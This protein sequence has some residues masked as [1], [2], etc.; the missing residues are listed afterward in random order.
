MVT[1]GVAAGWARE[2]GVVGSVRVAARVVVRE[3]C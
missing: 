1:K 2:E 3:G